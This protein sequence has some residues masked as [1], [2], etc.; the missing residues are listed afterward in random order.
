MWDVGPKFSEAA[1]YM[2]EGATELGDSLGTLFSM[3]T[4][5]DMPKTEGCVIKIQ[6]DLDFNLD[7]VDPNYK[8]CLQYRVY[9]SNTAQHIDLEDRDGELFK[10]SE[11]PGACRD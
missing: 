2:T 9:D 4:F 7:S 8:S 1:L 3:K 6:W 5:P 11:V 10:V